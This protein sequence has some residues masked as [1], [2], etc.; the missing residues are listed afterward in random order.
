M[1]CR[2][3]RSLMKKVMRFENGKSYILYRCPKCYAE[4]KA[5]R[6]FFNNEEISMKNTETN[7]SM[8]VVNKTIKKNKKKRGK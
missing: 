6:F 8:K 3:C 5:K 7:K 2:H 1:F 4:T